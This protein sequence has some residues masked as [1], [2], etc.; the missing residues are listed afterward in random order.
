MFSLA[1][2]R[3][4]GLGHGRLPCLLLCSS[5]GF[6][7]L[8]SHLESPVS[9]HFPRQGGWA[10]WHSQPQSHCRLVIVMRRHCLAV[11]TFSQ[12]GGNFQILFLLSPT[13]ASPYLGDKNRRHLKGF[14]SHLLHSQPRLS[15]N[16]CKPQDFLGQDVRAAGRPSTS[17]V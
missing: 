13:N 14:L 2:L 15:P 6:K 3:R 1:G 5:L 4:S 17:H 16:Q 9:G 10:R 7:V 8:C 12:L 11:W